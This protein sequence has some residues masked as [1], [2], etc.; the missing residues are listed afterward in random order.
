MCDILCWFRF[1]DIYFSF[2][3]FST[4]IQCLVQK[5]AEIYP[6]DGY[7]DS[8]RVTKWSNFKQVEYNW[9]IIKNW[10]DR[11]ERNQTMGVAVHIDELWYIKRTMTCFTNSRN[12]DHC[13]DNCYDARQLDKNFRSDTIY[14]WP[15]RYGHLR[16]W[17]SAI[18]Q[19]FYPQQKFWN[20]L[21]NILWKR[22]PF[23]PFTREW[24]CTHQCKGRHLKSWYERDNDEEGHQSMFT[25][26]AIDI[27]I[28]IRIQYILFIK[29]QSGMYHQRHQ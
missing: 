19:L 13:N 28:Q 26:H 29:L 23:F 6:L 10:W 8:Y 15:N 27:Q 4:E 18:F 14:I 7:T 24:H 21:N 3:L 9:I 2:S 1:W 20:W 17:D 25:M 5:C 22:R 12:L 16:S 11:S